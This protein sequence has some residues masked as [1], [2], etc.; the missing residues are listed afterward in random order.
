ME[1]FAN[2][3]FNFWLFGIS[4]TGVESVI[5]HKSIMIAIEL[6]KEQVYRSFIIGIKDFEDLK[7]ALKEYKNGSKIRFGA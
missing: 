7:T 4:S 1:E 6:F 2:C 5:R 3:I